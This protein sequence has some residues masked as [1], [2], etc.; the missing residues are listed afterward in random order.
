M[1]NYVREDKI[2]IMDFVA[3]ALETPDCDGSN[4]DP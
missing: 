1:E 3:N 2:S 4:T